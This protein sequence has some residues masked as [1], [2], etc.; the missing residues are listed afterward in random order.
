M[1][2]NHN[3]DNSKITLEGKTLE[4]VLLEIYKNQKSTIFWKRIRNII[5]LLTTAFIMFFVYGNKKITYPHGPYTAIIN[6]NTAITSS[7]KV[8][9]VII[10][11]LK[12]AYND[13]NVKGI[14]IKANSPGG[15]AVVSANI[16]DEILILKNNNPKIPLYVVVEDVCASGCYYIATA[17]DKIFANPSSLVGSIGVI[18]PGFGLDKFIAKYNIENRIKTSGRNKAMGDMF[19]PETA[20]QK[21]IWKNLL[22]D[23][24]QQFILSVKQGR[25]TRLQWQG[26]DQIFSGRIYTGIE[27]KKIGLIDDFGNSYKIARDVIKAPVLVD[28]TIKQNIYNFLTGKIAESFI[29]NLKENLNNISLYLY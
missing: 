26:D 7:K 20:E 21:E 11:S 23:V 12:K 13:K 5:Y 15:S 6:L 18:S 8:D 29:T 16:Y 3:E 27:G 4:K 9:E 17:A 1:N 25:G 2:Q 22:H 28:F 19:S 10:N 14:I 24:H